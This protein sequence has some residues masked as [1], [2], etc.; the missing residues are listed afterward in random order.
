MSTNPRVWKEANSLANEGYEVVVLTIWTNKNLRIKDWNHIHHPNIIYKAAINLIP[1]EI[2]FLQ[3]FILRLRNRIACE[4]KRFINIELVDSLG[5]APKKI[6]D[7][8]IKEKADLYIVHTELGF[9]CGK[10]LALKGY[11]VAFDF[12]D[13]Y[14]K[15]YLVSYRP[16]KLLE[17]LEF[18]ALKNG[19]Y[20]TCTSKAMADA[21]QKKYPDTQRSE[22]IYNGF[23]IKENR[24]TE[25][26][27]LLARSLVWFSQTIGPGRGLE[28]L[29][30]AIRMIPQ[31]TELHLIGEC[32]AGYDQALKSI[33]PFDKH[34]LYFHESMNHSEIVPYISVYTVGLALENNYPDNKN[35]TIS[36][37]I[38]QFLQAELFVL[39][40]D[41]KG[42]SEVANNFNE[43]IKLVPVGKA[44][45][46][47]NEIEYLFS[48]SPAN[49][50]YQLKIFNE[51]FSWEA[52]E[53]KL[54]NLVKSSLLK[55]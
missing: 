33:F 23:S 8:A 52:Q 31:K 25:Q 50:S 5:Y 1:G 53:N 32:V 22:V 37:K 4:I 34:A 16:V 12:E 11:S 9:Y 13:W 42:H 35:V 39:A 21:L 54:C 36:N 24:V 47:A 26:P 2:S 18:Y 19:V 43:L 48:S 41:T 45:I 55:G 17:A 40:T 6:I 49:N 14:S 20:C 46:W 10:E 15:D 29:I 51:I 30:Q 28:T 7:N 27:K 38:L 3:S 44:D